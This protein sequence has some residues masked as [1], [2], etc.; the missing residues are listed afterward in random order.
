[1]SIPPRSRRLHVAGRALLV[2]VAL[3]AVLVA[4]RP[5]TVRADD[6]CD[7]SEPVACLPVPVED[8]DAAPAPSAAPGIAVP[9]R[10]PAP[11]PAAAPGAAPGI[12]TFYP[13][14]RGCSSAAIIAAVN[15]ANVLYVRA[16]RTLDTGEARAAWGGQALADLVAQVASLRDLGN[17]ATPRLDSITLRELR[18]GGG[19]ARVRTIEHWLY[20]ERSQLSGEVVYEQ[21]QW[22]QNIYSLELRGGAWLVVRDVITLT[23]PPA[24]PAP[25]ASAVVTTD[26][27]SYAR[28]EVV[29]GTIT[30]D[31]GVTLWHG[32]G[33]YAC[34][35]LRVEWLGPNGW[36]KAP[37]N[38]PLR[39]CLAIAVAL[40][41]GESFHQTLPTGTRPGT[42]RLVFAYSAEGGPAGVAYSAPYTVQ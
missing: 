3:S 42:Y 17:Y 30:N 39:P 14:A 41:P 29:E 12:A 2:A 13:P 11:C 20:Q 38:E 26:R 7:P 10:P 36:Q 24:V 19:S 16:V 4:H 15:R 21:D 31:G 1:M 5:A 37:L 35:P 34:G 32:A 9:V 33:G 27:D 28:G 8:G 6:G 25:P 23:D 40:P 18:P 22:V